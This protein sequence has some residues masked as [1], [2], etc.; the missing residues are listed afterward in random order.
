MMPSDKA[1][2]PALAE[3]KGAESGPRAGGGIFQSVNLG[4]GSYTLSADIA[5]LDNVGGDN[6]DGG[7]F[8]LLFD[9]VVVDSYDFGRVA[10]GV[11]EYSMLATVGVTA[12]GSHEIRFRMT[13]H[14][15]QADATPVQYID[16]VVLI[17]E[18]TTFTL[19][20]LGS[21]ALVA[22]RRRR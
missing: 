3:N 10:V 8:E 22:A 17:P 20:S 13:R 19:L 15:L 5:V 12:S 16:N 21:L 4:A 6:N 1:N 11:A 2:N 14:Y 18:P 9:S 7:L